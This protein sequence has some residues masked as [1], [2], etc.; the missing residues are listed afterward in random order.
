MNACRFLNNTRIKLYFDSFC[1]AAMDVN[2]ECVDKD[3]ECELPE[4][5]L[6][7]Y[8]QRNDLD[9]ATMM[10]STTEVNVNKLSPTSKSCLYLALE[11]ENIPMVKLLVEH[12]A[13]INLSSYSN[14]FCRYESPLVTAV[15]LE[16]S[17]LIDMILELGCCMEGR[18]A[19]GK[20]EKTALQWAATYGNISLASKVLSHGAE[21]NWIGP[22][23]HTAL[24]Y[25]AIADKADM[26]LWL[27]EKEA[28]ISINGD[29]RSPL[30]IAAVRGNLP[31]VKYLFQYSCEIDIEDKFHFTPFSLACLRGH[32]NVVVYMLEHSPAGTKFHLDDGLHRAADSG[33]THVMKLLLSHGAD[34]NALNN[35]GE[36][37]L[38]TAARAGKALPVQLLLEHG[39]R[40]NVIDNRGYTPLQLSLLREQVDVSISLIQHGSV[41]HALSRN[42]ESPLYLAVTTSN[43]LLV[44]AVLL[45][46]CCLA[47]EP[48]FTSEHASSK[49][50]DLEYLMPGPL[51]FRRESDH[52][53][54]TWHWIISQ[55]GQPQV[56]RQLTRVTIRQQLLQAS[57]GTSV[58]SR[59][60]QLPLPVALRGFVALDDVL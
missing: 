9:M 2:K 43:P 10:L 34:A 48:W 5:M 32:H 41:L 31:I 49:L 59:V 20:D 14:T 46:G 28:E 57:Q 29:G 19:N 17:E 47:D 53:K 4:E 45:A 15:R 38:S 40:L 27:L 21:V 36:S 22:Y 52:Q 24:H 12:D 33:H 6:Y 13:D 50:Q 60:H 30:H 18:S 8:V 35:L 44:K 26:V 56:L 1:S 58:L 39:S 51:R 25:A 3:T 54:D 55:L 42:T 16:N 37:P 7:E 11:N 23:F